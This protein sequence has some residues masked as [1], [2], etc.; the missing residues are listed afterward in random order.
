[1]VS[2]VASHKRAGHH[3]LLIQ[4]PRVIA[5]FRRKDKLDKGQIRDGLVIDAARRSG[6]HS[7]WQWENHKTYFDFFVDLRILAV[8]RLAVFGNFDKFPL[9]PRYRRVIG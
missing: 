1:M 4:V 9:E 6:F 3:D 8:A 5:N 2:L 7:R